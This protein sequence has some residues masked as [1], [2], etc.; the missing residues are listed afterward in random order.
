MGKLLPTLSRLPVPIRKCRLSV[1]V[2]DGQTALGVGP[3]LGRG[4]MDLRDRGEL[5][6]LLNKH[7]IMAVRFYDARRTQR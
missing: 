5:T 6:V 2:Y 7:I 4:L 3:Q 1:T